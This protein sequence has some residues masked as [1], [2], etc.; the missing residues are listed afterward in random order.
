MLANTKTPITRDKHVKGC[1]IAQCEQALHLEESREVTREQHA[2]RDVSVK[3]GPLA[4]NAELA[5]WLVVA[6]QATQWVAGS[7][8]IHWVACGATTSQGASSAFITQQNA[9]LTGQEEEGD[10]QLKVS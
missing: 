9:T 1:S 6:P 5:P 3:G 2:K 4:I 7:P 8:V 10:V